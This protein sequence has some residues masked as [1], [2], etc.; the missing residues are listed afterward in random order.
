MSA[1]SYLNRARALKLSIKALERKRQEFEALKTAISSPMRDSDPVQTSKSG[2]APYARTVEKLIEID[3][4]LALRVGEY[5][6]T[7]AEMEAEIG[8]LENPVYVELLTR[9]YLDFQRFE[10]ISYEMQYSFA[11]TLN[12]HSEGLRAF[13]QLYPGKC[14]PDKRC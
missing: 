3:E 1:K 2:E 10:R 11:Y 13:E 7:L 5:A 9:R 6:D 12:L 14:F 4:S 8:R